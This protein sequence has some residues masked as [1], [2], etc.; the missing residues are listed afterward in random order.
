VDFLLLLV[1]SEL[2]SAG[3][4]P[5]FPLP[6]LCLP[7]PSWPCLRFLRSFSF[8]GISSLAA[9]WILTNGWQSLEGARE[10]S[11]QENYSSQEQYCAAT[12]GAQ[13]ERQA[14]V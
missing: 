3:K 1:C 10:F 13:V 11:M 7:G 12:N 5:C 8:G 9:T 14:E 2:V 6:G 4:C